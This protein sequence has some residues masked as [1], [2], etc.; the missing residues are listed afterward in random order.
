[1][2]H[3]CE[4]MEINTNKE[5][6]YN[7]LE[8]IIVVDQYEVEMKVKFAFGIIPGAAGNGQD[9]RDNIRTAY[10]NGV[11]VIFLA[12]SAAGIAAELTAER[13]DEL[14]ASENGFIK[15]TLSGSKADGALLFAAVKGNRYLAGH[16]GGGLIVRLDGSCTVLSKSDVG[17]P[18]ELKIYKGEIQEPFGFMLMSDAACRSLYESGSDKLS[19]AC[20]TFFDW[21][22]EYDEETVSEAL[23]DNMNKYFIKNVTGDIGVGMMVSDETEEEPEPEAVGEAEEPVGVAETEATEEAAEPEETEEAAEPEETAELPEAAVPEAASAAED[24]NIS[25][26]NR[27]LK[28]IVAALVIL[29]VAF[30]FAMKPGVSEPKEAANPEPKPQVTSSGTTTQPAAET[31]DGLPADPAAGQ[32]ENEPLVTFSPKDAATYDA[33]VYQVGEDIPAG[34]Y[35]FWTGDMLKPDSVNVNDVTCLSGELYC[36]TVKVGEGDTLATDVRFTAA[37]N[38]EPVKAANGTLISGKYRIG[39]DIVPGSYKITPL[40]QKTEGKYYSIL[41]GEISNDEA[42]S[43]GTTVVVPQEGYIVFYNAVLTVG[44]E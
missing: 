32:D 13:F 11:G 43:A 1:M 14:F 18:D 15:E 20:G 19:P 33:G 39:K 10:E 38:V 27:I 24:A 36:M 28:Y 17:A 9:R 21:L 12:G 16:M 23:T 22:K 34:E 4:K 40:D 35:F 44:Q 5:I 7:K 8:R 31:P 3:R 6:R 2:S 26:T 42:F 41:D 30:V 29:A 25:K 37:E